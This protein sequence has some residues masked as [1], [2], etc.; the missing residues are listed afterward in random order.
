MRTPIPF[1]LLFPAL[2]IGTRLNAQAPPN[3]A[4]SGAIPIACGGS[5]PG[6]T[7]TAT[8][9]AN[10][11]DCGTS[12]Q[13]AGVW[14]RIV[15]SDQSI[16]L[17]TCSDFSYD[18]R[19]NVYRGSCS[20][21]QC[22]AGNDDGG[23][24]DVGSTL[25]FAGDQGVTYYIL[26][27]GYE[28]ATGD[29]E[30]TAA[31]GAITSDFCQG[32]QAIAC[33]QSLS[34]STTEAS[35]DAVPFC[36][37]GVQAAGVWYTFTGV[38]GQVQLST[39]ESVSY[40]SRLNVFSGSC[41]NLICVTGND[42][43][44]NVGTCS[45]VNFIAEAGQTYHILVQGYDGE[46][47]DFL[48]EMACPTCGTPTAVNASAN[49]TSAFV[50]WYSLNPGAT[51]EIEY[52]PLGFTPGTGTM[53]TGAVSDNAASAQIDGLDAGT[54]YAFYLRE[55]CGPDD[56]SALVGVFTFT[57]LDSP[58]V[59]NSVC[60]GALPIACGGSVEG[61]T[62]ESFFLPG[63]HCGAAF[64]T[65]PGQWY[66][67]TGDGG[68]MTLSTCGQAEFDTK[69]SV[70]SGTCNALVCTAGGDDAPGCADNSTEV[71]FQTTSGMT[72]FAFVHAYEGQT[73]VF[74][75]S[76]EC[77]TGCAPVPANDECSGA[78][79]LNVAGI[80]LCSP[81]SAS[82]ACAYASGLPNPPCEPYNPVVDVWYRF[83]TGPFSS[84]TFQ[85][86]AL[87]A[88][89]VNAALYA[90]CG[91]LEYVDCETEIDGPWQLNNL[92]TGTTYYIRLW[93]G[94]GEDGGTMAVCLETDITTAVAEPTAENTVRLW[95]NPA[96]D[97]LTIAGNRSQ[98]IAVIDLQGRTVHTYTSNGAAQLDLDISA[99]APGS[100]V[101]RSLDDGGGMIGRFIKE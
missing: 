76:L 56:A 21:L 44:E 43:T 54:E 30:L 62:Q 48:L 37:T 24:C 67:F 94:G 88:A 7:A 69:I 50:D 11:I 87:G 75:L 81:S 27:Q 3:D 14:Y 17:S 89:E 52:G 65:A 29:F 5:V 2:L 79:V 82:N 28:G 83:E 95:P 51:Y 96:T 12:I 70:Y 98:R 80:G 92:E 33:N 42:D 66:T 15:G 40:D 46:T 60:S 32:G 97:R 59:V 39:C 45:T 18:T 58:P 19:L 53:A 84:F 22:V 61:D 20:G 13:A 78:S 16:T 35:G 72:Y 36:E 31:C 91:S 55:V 74:T 49:H 41:S 71:T 85:A 63:E 93:N 4:C 34:G 68:T 100:Y 47:G 10:A 1:I 25:S 57:T 6:S 38:E 86:S 23:G 64:I 90:D 26:V 9:D 8:P 77:G 101:V 99:L 73:G